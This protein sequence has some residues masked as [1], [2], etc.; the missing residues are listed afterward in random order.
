MPFQKGNTLGAKGRP[1][2]SKNKATDVSKFEL[3]QM[4]FNIEDMK[5]DFQTLDAYKKFD[6]RMKAMSFFYS[7]PTMEIEVESKKYLEIEYI[8]DIGHDEVTLEQ[9]ERMWLK[10][11]NGDPNAEMPLMFDNECA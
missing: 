5:K 9:K 10:Y 1:K 4:L 7:R 6:V 3:Q 8:T 2:G 11:G